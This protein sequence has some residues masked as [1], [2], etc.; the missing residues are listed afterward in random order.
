MTKNWRLILDDKGDGYCNMAVDEAL[1]LDYSSC[2]IPTLRIYGWNKPFISLGYNQNSTSVLG[3]DIDIPFVRRI[4]GGSAIL[5]DQELTYSL[6]CSLDD[7]GLPKAVKESY[8]TI[9]SFLKVFYAKLGLKADFAADIF[10]HQGLG[11]YNNFCFLSSQHFDLVIEGK[12]IGGNAQRRRKNIIFQHGSI[13]QKINPCQIEKAIKNTNKVS[14]ATTDL[15]SA[16]AKTTDFF[17]LAKLLSQSFA[18]AFGVKLERNSLSFKEQETC[19]HLLRQ[20]YSLE[21][22]NIKRENY[23]NCR[24]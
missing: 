21:E 18:G 13:P 10:S 11:E 1:L 5:H 24:A 20:K 19:H 23:F 12:K 17:Q 2:K 9:C 16:L 15:D 3:N 8:K 7:L 6:I 14:E 4:T 22:W